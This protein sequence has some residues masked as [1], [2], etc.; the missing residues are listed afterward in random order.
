MS[1]QLPASAAV[2]W[3]VLSVV[4]GLALV[5]G[6]RAVE[7]FQSRRRLKS[8]EASDP[9]LLAK[10][11]T[12]GRYTTPSGWTYPRIRV[13]Y[14]PHL[15]AD[16]LPKSIPLLVFT[17]GLGGSAAQFV[18]L[19]TSLINQA[20][21]LAIDLPGFGRSKFAPGHEKAYTT[22]A[23]AELVATIIKDY[24]DAEID[25]KVV[26]VGHSMGC[27][28]NALLASSTSPLSHLIGEK[29][30]GSIA[31]CPRGDSLT[32]DEV[33][34]V[35]RMSWLPSPIF[36]LL[37]LVDRRGGTA[38]R[39]VSRVV[40]EEA[41][42]ETRRMQLRFNMQS[43]S[44]PFLRIMAAGIGAEGMP[45]KAVWAGIKIPLFLVG[46]ESDHVT[47]AQEVEKIKG[48]LTESL[49]LNNKSQTPDGYSKDTVPATTGD[50]TTAKRTANPTNPQTDPPRMDSGVAIKDSHTTTRHAF[51][52]KT[53]IF[54]AP[55][56]HG[57]MYSTDTVRILSGMIEN[58]LSMHV[59]ERL[60]ASWQLQH[61]TTSGKW[62]VKNLKKWQAV[63]ACSEPIGGLFRAMKTM[64]E[65]DDEH[66]PEG[67]VEVYGV[68]RRQDGVSVVVDISHEA[69][70]Y[71]P[72]GLEERGVG[73]RKLP[74]VSKEKPK[75]EEVDRFVKLV[76]ELRG[77]G[78]LKKQ[79]EGIAGKHPTIGVHCHY[80]F[81]RTGFFIVCYLVE[82]EGYRLVD[83][84]REF[85]EKRPPGIKHDHFVNELYVRYAVKMERRGTVV[86]D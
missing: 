64:R 60:G 24:R 72:E 44:A 14:K 18:P 81:N 46:G 4:V 73:Y 47:P 52:L 36:D 84:I 50:T 62:D 27:S 6:W 69:P 10:H 2:R 23:L 83:A 13:F 42:N 68:G 75:A 61:L 33:A 71:H 34:L 31:I 82:R 25:Q 58:F 11:T 63:E 16:K 70:V 28:I 76:D 85:S 17:H 74:T 86:G 15:Y 7:K 35:R 20:P 45:G 66:S 9:S 59:D 77:E 55:A 78:R 12:F 1:G 5:G 30:V 80:G 37:R 43:E 41:D 67:F 51:A 26:L 21:C 65:V 49:H 39:S 54:P 40:G 29:V 56:S 3:T 53:T 22:H 8:A 79:D 32:S 48:W 19:L 57:L 38:S